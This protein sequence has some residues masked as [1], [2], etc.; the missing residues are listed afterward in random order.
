MQNLRD[1]LSAVFFF[2]ALAGCASAT[3]R[4]VA[5]PTTPT[6]P[7]APT[8]AA[9]T[10]PPEP[11]C[12]DGSSGTVRFYACGEPRAGEAPGGLPAPY[13]SLIHISEPTRP[14]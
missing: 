10:T 6:T 3:P 13:L 5:T 2:A 1:A 12:P 11:A 14:Y 8:P 4:S 9:V 7:V